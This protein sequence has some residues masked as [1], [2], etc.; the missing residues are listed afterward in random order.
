MSLVA[1]IFVILGV[2]LLWVYLLYLV[3]WTTEKVWLENTVKAYLILSMLVGVMA[4]VVLA[5]WS[6]IR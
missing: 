3:A 1:A 6:V 5:I 2:S 4:Q